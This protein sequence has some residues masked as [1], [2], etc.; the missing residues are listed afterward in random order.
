MKTALKIA[1]T[2]VAGIALGL[3]ATWLIVIRGG[4]PGGIDDGPWRTN[5]STGSVASDMYTRA[6]VAVH[7]LLALNRNE[8]IYYSAFGDSDGNALQGNC[9]YQ[10][11]GH[12][13]DAR[14][15][16]ITAYASDDYLIPNAAD[17]YSISK[18]TVRREEGGG[19]IATVGA[20]AVPKNW[21]PVGANDKFSLTLR[22]YN[23]GAGIV[24]DPEH[25]QLPSIKKVSC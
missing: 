18:T 4:V 23:P 17:R 14:W 7:G 8:T 11:T 12:D 24:R 16:S 21:I 10:L 9:T 2:L 5:L 19:F 25:A 22:L 1:A 15:W 3:L 6:A 20:D 13:P